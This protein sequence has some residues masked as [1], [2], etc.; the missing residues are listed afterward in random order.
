MDE[1]YSVLL[2]FWWPELYWS[3]FRHVR[4]DMSDIGLQRNSCVLECVSV[5]VLRFVLKISEM[6]KICFI[7]L[8]CK[9]FGDNII[10]SFAHKKKTYHRSY[11]VHFL[12][13]ISKSLIL[14]NY[15]FAARKDN[16]HKPF[17]ITNLK[18][19]D[20]KKMLKFTFLISFKQHFYPILNQAFKKDSFFY[21]HASEVE[22]HIYNLTK[23]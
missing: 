12:N 17:W 1:K 11:L 7:Y 20:G 9:S 10:S 19:V 21:R 2:C 14:L 4:V 6:S 5:Y 15:L 8:W 16:K 13:S 23:K 3:E 22:I 18:H